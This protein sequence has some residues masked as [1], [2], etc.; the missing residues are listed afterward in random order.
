[1]EIGDKINEEEIGQRS[2]EPK[3]LAQALLC[4]ASCTIASW[5]AQN[6]GFYKEQ[7][8]RF[9][10]N[11]HHHKG[12]VYIILTWNDTFTIY[13]ADLDGVIV[14]KREEVYI[15]ELID[16][17]DKRIEWIDDYKQ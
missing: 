15:D 11:G 8:L 7:W 4:N 10:V 5:G 16:V 2:F 14:E 3:E 1:M 17:L 9:M 6:W 12:W 13:F